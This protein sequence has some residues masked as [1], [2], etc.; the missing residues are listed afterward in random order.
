MKWSS[1][2]SEEFGV[3]DAITEVVDAVQADLEGEPPDLA[4]VFVSPHHTP[5]FDVVSHAVQESLAPKK[6]LG[7]SGG[8]VIGG[9]REVENRTGVS[10]ST[11]MLPDVEIV[12]FSVLDQDLPDL[13]AS[14]SAWE[15]M[16]GITANKDPHFVL[17]ADPYSIQT[18]ALI[19][20]LDYAFPGSVKVGGL[21]SGGQ[22][23][24]QNALFL[25]TDFHRAGAVGVALAG[26]IRVDTI[27]AQGCR[28]IGDA[29]VVTK[30]QGNILLELDE[31]EP[32]QVLRKEFEAA[33]ENDRRLIN[34]ALHLGVVMDPLKTKFTQGDFL[35]RN[36]MG[37][38]KESNGLAIGEVLREG[39]VVQ[40]HVRDSESAA[41]DL[42]T[43]LVN[44]VKEWSGGARAG[45]LLFSCLGRGQHLFGKPDHD[46][47]LFRNK[48]GDTPLGGFFC[49]G[50]IGPVGS[51]TFLHGFT[52]S[53]GIFSEREP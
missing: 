48:V 15:E 25:N 28:P 44:H 34:S 3:K 45:A 17:L 9:G 30:S 14:P 49:N 51:S 8:G 31:Q 26:N 7:C 16:V 50:E 53:F 21:A 6:L 27:V 33:N 40:F 12:T 38:Q 19:S 24:G 39:Q 42:D 23:P 1:S 11:A 52:S 13:D 35:I 29:H 10:L 46:T 43:L 5:D 41:T 22:G 37:I 32:M 2:V 36:V 47:G 20:G 18:D 4:V